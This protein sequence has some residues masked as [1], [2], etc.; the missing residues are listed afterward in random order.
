VYRF[1][2]HSSSEFHDPIPVRGRLLITLPGG[3]IIGVNNPK[4]WPLLPRP[5]KTEGC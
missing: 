3:T 4:G 1:P 2:T 5:Q